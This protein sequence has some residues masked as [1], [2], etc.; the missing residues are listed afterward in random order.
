MAKK[1]E[2]LTIFKKKLKQEILISFDLSTSC[3]GWAIFDIDTKELLDSGF[4]KGSEKG[5]SKLT[6]PRRQ[7]AK[8][9]AMA[10]ILS[11][12]IDQIDPDFIVIE[13]IN[14]GVSRLGQKTLDGLHWIFLQKFKDHRAKIIYKDS[15]GL[16]GWRKDLDLNL[17][18][19]DKLKN[20]Q[21]R[22]FNS[23]VSKK[24]Q[25]PIIHKKHVAVRFVN[26]TFNKTHSLD[27]KYENSPTYVDVC[28][29]ICCGF[30]VVQ[31]LKL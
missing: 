15:D 22:D 23:K 25:K 24:D 27:F 17:S 2:K 8:M 6:Y 21:I 5:L 20:K 29:A 1:D 3:S 11:A 14:S 13:E 9:E 12:L 16:S 28:D 7:L 10:G 30:S 19:D 4:V 18:K 26:K 31:Q